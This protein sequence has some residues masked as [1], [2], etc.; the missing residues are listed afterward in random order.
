MQT[1]RGEAR[2]LAPIVLVIDVGVAACLGVV[3]ASTARGIASSDDVLL[4][5]QV[6]RLEQLVVNAFEVLSFHGRSPSIVG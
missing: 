2:A 4:V 6:E 3:T 1:V 5:F